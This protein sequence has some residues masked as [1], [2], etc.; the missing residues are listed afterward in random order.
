M[1][2]LSS[3]ITVVET[4]ETPLPNIMHIGVKPGKWDTIVGLSIVQT[5]IQII[6][7]KLKEAEYKI[8]I[9]PTM[10]TEI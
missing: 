7:G 2:K 9:K 4:L 10:Q 1:P 3:R 5:G 6:Q 8:F